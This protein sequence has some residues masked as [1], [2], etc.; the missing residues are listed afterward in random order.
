VDI[1][2]FVLKTTPN[3]AQLDFDKLRFPLTLRRWKSGDFFV[4][5]GQRGKQKLSDFFVNQKLSRFDKERVWLLCSG[6]EIVWIVGY[7]IDNRY[8]IS[9][10]TKRVLIIES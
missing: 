3:V 9:S 8:R 10:K 7:R 1:E 5:F 2:D 6:E 4:P